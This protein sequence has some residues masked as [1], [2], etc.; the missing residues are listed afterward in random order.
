MPTWSRIAAGLVLA[1]ALI[2]YAG[3]RAYS[4]KLGP[5]VQEHGTTYYNDD[6][7]PAPPVT[8]KPESEILAAIG[9]V[10]AKYDYLVGPDLKSFEDRATLLKGLPPLNVDELY[11]ITEDDELRDGEMVLFIGL[12]SNCVTTVFGFSA[13]VYHEILAASGAASLPPA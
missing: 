9:K 7:P 1:I 12:K 4:E 8:C 10:H 11:V 13:K 3:F 5:L 2:G 6:G